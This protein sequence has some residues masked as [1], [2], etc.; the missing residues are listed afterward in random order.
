LTTDPPHLFTQEDA[1]HGVALQLQ[2]PI[3]GKISGVFQ[4]VGSIL[5]VLHMKDESIL[6]ALPDPDQVFTI[7]NATHTASVVF[8]RGLTGKAAKANI[9][10]KQMAKGAV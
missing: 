1:A 7:R 3:T 10:T 6:G 2:L 8:P 5:H 4:N 9:R